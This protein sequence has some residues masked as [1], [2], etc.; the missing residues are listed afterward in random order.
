MAVA[1]TCGRQGAAVLIYICT[2]FL[3]MDFGRIHIPC[4]LIDG[5]EGEGDSKFSPIF[6]LKIHITRGVL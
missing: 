4:S 2:K 3:M 6:Q 5:L 1:G